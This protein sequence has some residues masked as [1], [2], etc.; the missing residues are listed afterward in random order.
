MENLLHETSSCA[1]VYL[2]PQILTLPS[3][4]SQFKE[5][6]DN[7]SYIDDYKKKFKTFQGHL[8]YM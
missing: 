6:A 7:R 1:N 5:A 4:S 3:M 2:A 8:P